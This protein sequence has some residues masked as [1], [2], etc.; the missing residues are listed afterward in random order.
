MLLAR[1]GHRVLLVDRARFPSDTMSTHLIK[2]AGVA[3]LKRWILLEAVA[4]SG[5]PPIRRFSFDL[6][7]FRLAG[8]PTPLDGIAEAYAPRRTVLDKILVDAA[9][10]AGVEVREGFAVDDLLADSGRVVGIRG[11]SRGGPVVAERARLVVGADGRRAFVAQAVDASTYDTRPP[12]TT[13]YYTYWA[14]VP[15]D[16]LESYSRDRQLTIA[17]PTHDG[18]ACT[19][20]QWPRQ[21][22]HAVRADVE[23]SVLRALEAIAPDLAVRVRD[24]RRAERFVG[25]A[26]L[27]SFFRRPYGSGWALVGDAGYHR[28]PLAAWGITDAFRDAELLADAIDAGLSGCRSM[29]DALAEYEGRRNE[30][31]RPTYEATCRRA[32]FE[33]PS[34]HEL[35]LRAALREDPAET[36]RY[37]GAALGT[38]PMR[39]FFAPEN[40]ERIIGTQ[41][42]K[43]GMRGAVT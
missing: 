21:E 25:T 36:S 18:L 30:A 27:P 13:T 8:S 16:G 19:F 9:A 33:P 35:R 7:D 3:R 26:D 28:D 39:E 41:S 24:G 14:D 34:A 23:G 17:F 38:V 31:A 15:T 11:R 20:H 5:C 40:V 32:A 6:G 1:R 29:D 22:F 42:G 2:P 12:L 37:L 10:D 43:H 4:G